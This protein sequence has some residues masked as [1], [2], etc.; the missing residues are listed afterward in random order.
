MGKNLFDDNALPDD[1]YMDG[2]D[3]EDLADDEELGIDYH[4]ILHPSESQSQTDMQHPEDDLM[5][6]STLTPASVNAHS[7]DSNAKPIDA[8]SSP[9]VKSHHHTRAP[10]PSKSSKSKINKL[11]HHLK[12]HKAAK[13]TRLPAHIKAKH[14]ITAIVIHRKHGKKH[15]LV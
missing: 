14:K 11:I 15:V 9:H 6:V 2:F 13:V 8:F 12:T 1:D 3:D 7:A 10:K 5:T 4:E